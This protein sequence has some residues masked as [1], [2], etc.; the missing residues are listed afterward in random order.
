MYQTNL[1]DTIENVQKIKI[2]CLQGGRLGGA[3][4]GYISK[5]FNASNYVSIF[6]A[7]VADYL[8]LLIDSIVESCSAFTLGFLVRDKIIIGPCDRHFYDSMLNCIGTNTMLDWI[9]I[10]HWI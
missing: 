1:G 8:F 10:K 2:I 7:W 4:C 3:N 6:V 9:D 5:K